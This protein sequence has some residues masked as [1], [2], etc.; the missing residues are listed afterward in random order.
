MEALQSED[1]AENIAEPVE[2][3][4]AWNYQVGQN[5]GRSWTIPLSGRA[6]HRP[7]SAAERPLYFIPSS[8]RKAVRTLKKCF[9]RTKETMR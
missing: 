4:P 8:V 1:S 3:T 2:E 6:D 9:L 5:T 7:G